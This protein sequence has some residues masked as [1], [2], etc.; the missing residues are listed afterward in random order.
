MKIIKTYL[1][2]DFIPNGIYLFSSFIDQKMLNFSPAASVMKIFRYFIIILPKFLSQIMVAES[3][4]RLNYCL[5]QIVGDIK[6]L[7]T[8]CER[9]EYTDLF[10]IFHLTFA[11]RAENNFTGNR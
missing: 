11:C 9:I 4:S 2:L 8:S 10:Q 5:K 7:L 6:A 3:F 1:K